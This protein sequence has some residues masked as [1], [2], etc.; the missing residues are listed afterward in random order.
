MA[1]VQTDF[2]GRRAG[3][4]TF[5]V[6]RPSFNVLVPNQDGGYRPVRLISEAVDLRIIV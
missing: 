5:T 6:T 3:A 1:A 4:D 2:A